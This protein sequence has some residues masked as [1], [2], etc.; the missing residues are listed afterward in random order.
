MKQLKTQLMAIKKQGPVIEHLLKIK[1][2]VDSLVAVSSPISDEDYVEVI[3]D[4]LNEDYAPLITV[5]LSRSDP[6]SISELEV[7][8]VA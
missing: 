5:V 6:F 1:K 4:G 8:L 7:L 2:I 3:L